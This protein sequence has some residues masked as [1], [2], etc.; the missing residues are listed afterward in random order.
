MS[1][2]READANTLDKPAQPT[3]S[4]QA[5]TKLYVWKSNRP[6]EAKVIGRLSAV[7]Q[8]KVLSPEIGYACGQGFHCPEASN[9][10]FDE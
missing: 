6:Y 5:E 8:V 10:A 1:A 7:T 3:L 4:R 9:E 2:P